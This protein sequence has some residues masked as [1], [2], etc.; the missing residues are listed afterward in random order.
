MLIIESAE[1]SFI[2]RLSKKNSSPDA[3][4][5]KGKHRSP[6]ENHYKGEYLWWVELCID[7]GKRGH[8]VTDGNKGQQQSMLQL[9]SF[10]NY[11]EAEEKRRQIEFAKIERILV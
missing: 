2:D 7:K 11:A 5:N 4:P 10:R 8:H 3:G 9:E 6:S 1:A